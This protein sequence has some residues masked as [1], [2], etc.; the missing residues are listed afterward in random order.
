MN[1]AKKSSYLG[2]V[3]S[4]RTLIQIV[5]VHVQY[6]EI[7]TGRLHNVANVEAIFVI[8]LAGVE[9]ER[10][11]ATRRFDR[12]LFNV[13]P[14]LFKEREPESRAEDSTQRFYVEADSAILARSSSIT[15]LSGL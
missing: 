1:I 10:T 7:V 14:E 3:G 8:V 2:N 9:L 12:Y 15:S 5:D 4:R 11:Q 6:C 13:T